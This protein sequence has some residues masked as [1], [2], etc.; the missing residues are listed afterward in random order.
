MV[1]REFLLQIICLITGQQER[2]THGR[3]DSRR[4]RTQAVRAGSAGLQLQ[5]TANLPGAQNPR[6]SHSEKRQ[7]K[8][9]VPR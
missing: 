5:E 3:R 8:F 7:R 4:D 9:R 2:D 6:R 1:P